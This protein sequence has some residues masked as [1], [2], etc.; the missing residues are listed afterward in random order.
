MNVR[1]YIPALRLCILDVSLSV[2]HDNRP[3]SQYL[4]SLIP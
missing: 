2:G 4:A 3:S 1:G